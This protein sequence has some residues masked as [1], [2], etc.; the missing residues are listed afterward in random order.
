MNNYLILQLGVRAYDSV[1]PSQV[2]N[3]NVT[4]TVNRNPTAPAFTLLNYV[5]TIV[6]TYTLGLEIL[7]VDATDN[8]GV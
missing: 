1:R 5:E 2:A 4:I 8:D 3:A 6:E 7:T